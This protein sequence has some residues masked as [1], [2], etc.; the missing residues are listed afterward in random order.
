MH[1]L[2]L[3]LTQCQDDAFV[4]FAYNVSTKSWR[5]LTRGLTQRGLATISPRLLAY[6][7][8]KVIKTGKYRVVPAVD[9]RRHREAAMFDHC[10]CD[11][12]L[13]AMKAPYCR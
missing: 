11:S 8:G 2:K 6:N 5:S 9:L 1:A 10:P 12:A 3:Q 13:P 4:S 7:K